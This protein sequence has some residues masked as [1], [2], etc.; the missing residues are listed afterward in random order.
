MMLDYESLR[1][2]WWLLVAVLLIGYAVMDGFDLGVA[3]LLPWVARTD[4][5]R[6]VLINSIGPTWDGNQVWL[7]L[8]AGA[9][10]A[11]WPIVY[12][13]AFSGMY[14]ALLLVLFALFM[15]PVG[16]DYRS[17]MPQTAWRTTWDY[18]LFVGG[19]VPA[20]VI[21]VAFGN[22]LQGVPFHFDDTMRSFYTG[23]FWALLNPFALLTGLVSV[24]M[25]AMHGASFLLIKTEGVVQQRSLT[26][27]RIAAIVTI[28]L[29]AVAG[30]WVANGIE[31]YRI[32][33]T[34]DLAGPSN[35]LNKEV[36]LAAGAW[37][38][39]FR[40]YPALW[41]VP[42]LGFAGAAIVLLLG[43]GKPGLSFIASGVSVSGIAAT[44]GV[45]LF[46]FVLPS[47]TN[48]SQ[49]LT[50]WDATSSQQTLWLMLIAALIFMPIILAYTSWVF[51]VLRGKVTEESI[52]ANDHAVY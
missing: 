41:S 18:A 38:D 23:S 43:K 32:V 11:A 20:L 49:S 13:A 3:T 6:R 8:G 16:F 40:H 44:A 47:S 51:R 9:V 19:F 10:F 28:A 34:L 7:I 15:R 14:V 27:S 42:V 1:L 50:M 26:A 37:L 24:A 29:F 22:F 46:P 35:P 36:V 5:E 21:G 31:G 48:P 33:G 52:R 45:A 2:I 17:K 39:N 30:F 4:G 25:L 12:A